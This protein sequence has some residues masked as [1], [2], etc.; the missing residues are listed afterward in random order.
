MY[1]FKSCVQHVI[2]EALGCSVALEDINRTALVR[3]KLGLEEEGGRF[4]YHIP[5][6]NAKKDFDSRSLSPLDWSS[7]I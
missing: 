6:K 3:L 5:P 2:Q 7:E 4:P 1:S